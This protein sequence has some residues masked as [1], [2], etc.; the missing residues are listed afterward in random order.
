ML[1]FDES[2]PPLSFL[3]GAGMGADVSRPPCR[4]A[5]D[6][7]KERRLQKEQMRHEA[8]GVSS[9]VSPTPPTPAQN[10]QPK[11]LEDF[12]S[13]SL[14]DN[15]SHCLEV[16]RNFRVGT[17]FSLLMWLGVNISLL[18]WF[19]LSLRNSVFGWAVCLHN[20]WIQSAWN[21]DFIEPSSLDFYIGIFFKAIYGI[22]L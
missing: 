3:W 14:P 2:P 17:F 13:E 4:K 11:L 15:A 21:F 12:I 5:K 6:L 18:C 20:V 1:S 9:I 7:R 19:Q 8:D 22:I 10:N 16:S